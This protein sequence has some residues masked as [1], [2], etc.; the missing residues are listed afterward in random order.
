MTYPELQTLHE[1][2]HYYPA[3]CNI[4]TSNTSHTTWVHSIEL[5][6]NSRYIHPNHLAHG[7]MDQTIG[8][9]FYISTFPS[10]SSRRKKHE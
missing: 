4:Q 5:R 7:S 2:D 3:A 1:L 8:S 9:W 6:P 10:L